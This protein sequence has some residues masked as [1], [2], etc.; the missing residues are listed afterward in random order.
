[1]TGYLAPILTFLALIGAAEAGALVHLRFRSQRPAADTIEVVRFAANIF[2]VMTSVVLGLMVD[3]AKNTYETNTNNLHKLAT[4]LILLDRN[5]RTLGPE[6][7]S[8]REQLLRYVQTSLREADILETDPQAEAA[9]DAAGLSLRAIRISDE[10]KL[11]LWNDARQIYRQVVRDRWTVVDAAG[12]TIPT[13]M[14]VTLIV[15][16]AAIFAGMG[17]RTPRN[18][19]VTTTF[20]AAALLLSS[21]LY[22][23]LEMDRPTSG[24]MRISNA[25]FVRALEQMQR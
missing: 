7:A 25:P 18:A 6:G 13:P 19:V 5:L 23:I 10:Q 14:L 17:Y 8:V 12:G 2:V 9:L 22:L 3:S 20:L 1:M 15:W 11:A 16:L 4:E 24:L 21:A